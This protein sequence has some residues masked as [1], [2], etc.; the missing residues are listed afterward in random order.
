MPRK[1]SEGKR[2]RFNGFQL[3]ESER[4]RVV[5]DWINAQPNAAESIKALI[6]KEAVGL[7]W[8]FHQGVERS[9]KGQ[10]TDTR[11]DID[12]PRV[13]ALASLDT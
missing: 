3:G 1:K 7:H 10:E 2:T 4:D 8:A 5:A 6:Y 11:L 13:K 9:G 12:D